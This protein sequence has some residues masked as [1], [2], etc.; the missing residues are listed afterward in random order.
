MA[1]SAKTDSMNM[2]EREMLEAVH[3]EG[4][5]T[6]KQVSRSTRFSHCSAKNKLLEMQ[7]AGYLKARND[8]WRKKYKVTLAALPEAITE[9]LT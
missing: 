4:W 3:E 1:Q 8:G 7:R 9:T 6:V 5:C 2:Q